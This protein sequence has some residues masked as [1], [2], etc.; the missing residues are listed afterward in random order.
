LYARENAYFDMEEGSS[1]V[2]QQSLERKYAN[3]MKRSSDKKAQ[4]ECDTEFDYATD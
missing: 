3:N 1:I 4:R 2:K